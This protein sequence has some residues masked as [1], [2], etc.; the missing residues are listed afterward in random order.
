MIESLELFKLMCSCRWFEKSSM[1][2]FLNKT[3]LFE[4]KIKT[5]PITVLFKDYNG[6]TICI[7]AYLQCTCSAHSVQYSAHAVHT[8]CTC[9]A[10]AVHT[11]EDMHYGTKFVQLPFMLCALKIHSFTL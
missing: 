4:E 6:E 11:A 8:Q 3:D 5:I 1:I 7:I 2:L 10:H 9:S